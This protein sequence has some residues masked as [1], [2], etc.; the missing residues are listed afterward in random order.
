MIKIFDVQNYPQLLDNETLFFLS[1]AVNYSEF[2]ILLNLK[3]KYSNL[4]ISYAVHPWNL[5]NTYE[6]EKFFSCK[7]LEDID[8]IGETG[9]D[10][11]YKN[12]AIK[13]Q[14]YWFKKHLE[15]AEE[16]NKPVIIHCRGA[17]YETIRILKN[18]KKL[19]TLIFHNFN[20]NS[21]IAEKLL[22]YNTYFSYNYCISGYN[23]EKLDALKIIPIEKLLFETDAPYLSQYDFNK[24]TNNIECVA[25]IIS[26]QKKIL[27]EDIFKSLYNNANNL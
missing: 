9:L 24:I 6:L 17:Y 13:T 23:Q 18:Y 2:I 7:K 5:K 8:A 22:D 19:K 20:G 10:A 14:E 4:Y 3:K 26:Q 25:K 27:V 1:N 11:K 12:I 21:D 16:L 15:K